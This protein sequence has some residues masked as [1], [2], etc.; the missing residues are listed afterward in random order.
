MQR[1]RPAVT[2][3]IASPEM[4]EGF[5]IGLETDVY[6]FGV[7]MWEV[8]TRQEAWHWVEGV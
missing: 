6:G 7:V 5:G 4:F 2:A 3:T 1:P 8:F